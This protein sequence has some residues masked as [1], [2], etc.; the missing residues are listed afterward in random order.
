MCTSSGLYQ[1]WFPPFFWIVYLAIVLGG[2]WRVWQN[3]N[4]RLRSGFYDDHR[5]HGIVV[6]ETLKIATN[7][8][9]WSHSQRFRP[10]SPRFFK[11][12]H[13]T[14]RNQETVGVI[15]DFMKL[16]RNKSDWWIVHLAILVPSFVN[17]DRERFQTAFLKSRSSICSFLDWVNHFRISVDESIATCNHKSNI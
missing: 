5:F 14:F 16:R 15:T 9:D 17:Q 3:T 1:F 7:R 8:Y 11:I 2:T 13:W 6:Y 4:G 10:P 12:E